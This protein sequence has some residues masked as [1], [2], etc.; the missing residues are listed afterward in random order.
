MIRNGRTRRAVRIAAL[1]AITWFSIAG[2]A[3]AL[4]PCPTWFP[5]F[6]CER[7]GRYDGFVPTMMHPYLFEDPF[8]TT[9]VSAWGVWHQFPEHS[10]LEGGD[11]W[12]AALQARVAITDRVAFIATKDGWVDFNPGLKLLG[13][14]G[15]F[16]DITVG[17]KG[18]LIDKP[19]IPF[20]LSPSLRF[21]FDVG[22]HSILQGNG[23]G[24][25]IPAVSAA[26]GKGD[27]HVIADFGGQFPMDTDAN[28]TSLF[29]HLHA[30]YVVHQYF[31]PFVEVG[32][33]HYL[34]GGDGSMDVKLTNGAHVELG[35]AQTLLGVG[36]FE[37]YDYA[38]LGS[39]NVAGNDVV[40]LSVGV[41]VPINK[42]LILG[43]AYE[44]PLTDRED[45]LNQR[46]AVNATLEF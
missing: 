15:G 6:R 27:F 21:M 8:I 18:S 28:S 24:V 34:D 44:I 38:N 37:G 19:E 23:D 42:H 31:V 35:T 13:D 1:S 12:V 5:D 25:W 43:A 22:E 32:G 39:R 30:D 4:P 11:L 16:A 26:W 20:I 33:F 40:A 7:H 36:G 45:V 9:G 2:A 17:F 3:Q 41:R 29:Y 46:A 10:L 14:D